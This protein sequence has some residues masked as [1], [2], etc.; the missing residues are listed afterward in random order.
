MVK[1][2]FLLILLFFILFEGCS[3]Q[4]ILRNEPEEY[5]GWNMYGGNCR[6]S[7]NIS[8]S[9]NPPL[10]LIKKFK[11]SS[12]LGLSPICS[13][14]IIYTG[15]LDG[16]I[17][18]FNIVRMSKRGKLKTGVG[19]VAAPVYYND[20]LY[21]AIS[22]ERD[23]FLCY[24]ISK[25][26][27]LWRKRLGHIESSPILYN[28]KLFVGTLDGELYCLNS[29]DGEIIWQ[30]KVDDS[31]YSSPAV[32][33][34]SVIIGTLDGKMYSFDI[35]TG[36]KNWEIDVKGSI[37]SSPSI[38]KGNIFI[39]TIEN[40]FYAVDVKDGD[41]KWEFDS[42]SKIYSTAATDE[43][44]VIFG[45]NDKF[46]YALNQENGEL[47]WKFNCGGLINASPVIA[48][49]EVYFGSLN[50]NIYGLDLNTGELIWTYQTAGKIKT[51]PII[52]KNYLIV[53]SEKKELFV[54]SNLLFLKK[55]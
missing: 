7:N 18:A 40:K 25:G 17:E 12:S 41:I 15:S 45:C 33:E 14:G 11:T 44:T 28:D 21:F 27:H 32:W 29:E 2:I 4:L 5:L 48:G 1:K 23:T 16:K 47:L 22:K 49:K 51:S 31:I 8:T 50:H 10:K 55:K 9:L 53:S 26:R 46:L 3:R 39:G 13:N 19:I 34:N 52:Y 35:N 24:S 30:A 6:H 37:F 42:N 36:K 38:S 20:R 54:F 43:K